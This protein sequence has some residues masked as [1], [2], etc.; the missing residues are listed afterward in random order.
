MSVQ[1]PGDAYSSR[2]PARHRHAGLIVAL[3]LLLTCRGDSPSIPAQLA[4][5][6]RTHGEPCD[7][8]T[9]TFLQGVRVGAEVWNAAC[10]NGRAYIVTLPTDGPTT[11]VPCELSAV[12]CFTTF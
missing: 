12:P 2:F 11:I 1:M 9:R 5:R 4:A 3:A 6:I 8:V 7:T 10:A